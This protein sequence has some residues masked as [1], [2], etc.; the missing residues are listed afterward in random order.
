MVIC[1]TVAMCPP[2]Y[3]DANIKVTTPGYVATSVTFGTRLTVTCP[4]KMYFNKDKLATTTETC[5]ADGTWFP[6]HLS[7][8]CELLRCCCRIT[9]AEVCYSNNNID[10]RNKIPKI[11]MV[12]TTL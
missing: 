6:A 4:F 12:V 8:S 5:Q 11:E 2:Y 3:P 7:C 9:C 10:D 1:V